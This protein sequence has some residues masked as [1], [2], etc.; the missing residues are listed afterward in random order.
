MRNTRESAV[1]SVTP[2]MAPPAN[3]PILGTRQYSAPE[4]FLGRAG[5]PA[6]DLFSLAVITYQLLTGQLPYGTAVSQATS[7]AAQLRLTYRSVSHYRQDLP[8]W[9]DEV[10]KKALQP[11]PDKRHGALSE[12]VFALGQ[13]AHPGAAG[14]PASLMERNPVAVW[15]GVSLLLL[16]LLM[17]AVLRLP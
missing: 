15:Q 3:E 17:L 1:P 6:S 2:E 9:L 5:T 16:V 14:V 12:F 11:D 10:L 4:Y 8:P 13:P 7:R